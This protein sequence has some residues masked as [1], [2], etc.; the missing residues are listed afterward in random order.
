MSISDGF[1]AGLSQPLTV[2]GSQLPV[3]MAEYAGHPDD[4]LKQHDMVYEQLLKQQQRAEEL[5]A[6][7][8]R[9]QAE[10]LR[11]ERQE[12][13][14][15]MSEFIGSNP[16]SRRQYLL[17]KMADG[18]EAANGGN[19]ETPPPQEPPHRGP[20]IRLDSATAT[21]PYAQGPGQDE[22]RRSKMDAAGFPRNGYNNIT[23]AYDAFLKENPPPLQPTFISGAQFSGGASVAKENP[24][25]VSANTKLQQPSQQGQT[26]RRDPAPAKQTLNSGDNVD[27]V[28]G[29]K[30]N[31]NSAVVAQP[32]PAK[33]ES[34]L[35]APVLR[36]QS[37]GQQA[38]A[39]AQAQSPAQAPIDF[40]TGE[41]AK[42]WNYQSPVSRLIEQRRR[43]AARPYPTPIRFTVPG[44]LT[45]LGTSGQVL[46]RMREFNQDMRGYLG[47]G[48]EDTPAPP[49]SEPKGMWDSLKDNLQEI[50]TRAVRVGTT[51][52]QMLASKA[53]DSNF[54]GLRDGRYIDPKQMARINASLAHSFDGE[55]GQSY[56]DRYNK[57]DIDPDAQGIQRLETNLLDR[58]AF[59]QRLI[60]DEMAGLQ[61]RELTPTELADRRRSIG[62]RIDSVYGF[63]GNALGT[64]PIY[65][66]LNG[67][68]VRRATNSL[69]TSLANP[70]KAERAFN[71]AN[72]LVQTND[73]AIDQLKKL[74]NELENT[75]DKPDLTTFVA[76][77]LTRLTGEMSSE[78]RQLEG[79]NT[80]DLEDDVFETAEERFAR[81]NKARDQVASYVRALADKPYAQRQLLQ[82]VSPDAANLAGRLSTMYAENPEQAIAIINDLDPATARIIR[83]QVNLVRGF[84][85]EKERAAIKDSDFSEF[86]RREY[87]DDIIPNLFGEDTVNPALQRVGGG[88]YNRNFQGDARNAAFLYNS[89]HDDKHSDEWY[90][91]DDDRL[92][93]TYYNRRTGELNRELFRDFAGWLPGNTNPNRAL[94][95]KYWERYQ[96]LHGKLP[97]Y[98]E[99]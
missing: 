41:P 62:S 95:R 67:S 31:S 98:Q 18:P 47:R 54:L 58:Q 15:K 21:T 69:G 11:A 94:P 34:A 14:Y 85:P 28:S 93:N 99:N 71:L 7:R 9:Q 48:P 40:T 65:E 45:P 29:L 12:E 50:G 81:Y 76:N 84:I 90:L 26:S 24:R 60:E 87:R 27:G 64:P 17:T 78:A 37:Q 73:P 46:N 13:G 49:P 52:A 36:D 23:D 63:K 89:M 32:P 5:R 91:V 70:G 19:L 86:E 30:A 1:R 96:Q 66:D 44:A 88:N 92:I 20:V 8:Q 6:E 22:M 97:Q 56:R 75:P 3:T 55:Y 68:S 25:A 57:I 82:R 39:Q 53:Y 83:D 74:Y 33:S 79:M 42:P 16:I 77:E 80:E 35:A 61:D 38:P 72:E 43:P 4:I 59:R 10:E 2:Q 51:G